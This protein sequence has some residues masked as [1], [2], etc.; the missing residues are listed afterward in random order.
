MMPATED[1]IHFII[2]RADSVGHSKTLKLLPIAI[3]CFEF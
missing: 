3:R 2:E 1:A